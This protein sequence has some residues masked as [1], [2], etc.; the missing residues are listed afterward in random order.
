MTTGYHQELFLNISHAIC[1][2]FVNNATMAHPYKWRITELRVEKGYSLKSFFSISSYKELL[3]L[4]HKVFC[5]LFFN[6][7]EK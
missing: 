3:Y 4:E 5:W 1:Y 2:F 7:S 6:T